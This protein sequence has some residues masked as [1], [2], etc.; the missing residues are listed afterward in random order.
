MRISSD[1]EF[2][3]VLHDRPLEF[4]ALAE[5]ELE[6][7]G[8]LIDLVPLE[9]LQLAVTIEP[10]QQWIAEK[11][12]ACSGRGH[13]LVSLRAVRGNYLRSAVIVGDRCPGHVQRIRKGYDA[14]RVCISR[15]Y[16]TPPAIDQPVRQ[17]KDGVTPQ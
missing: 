6:E 4:D 5:D 12:I 8:A 16:A 9:P 10:V 15:R 13:P 2:A 17:W 7:V 3:Q 11:V 1:I 14:L